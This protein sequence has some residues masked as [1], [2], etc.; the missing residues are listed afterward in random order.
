MSQPTKQ[1]FYPNP[2][3]FPS[4]A[5]YDAHRQTLDQVY[6]LHDR[7]DAME[8]KGSA[9]SGKGGS[10]GSPSSLNGLPVIG[11]PSKDQSTLIF[12]A[13]TGQLEWKAPS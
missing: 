9:P 12:N 11:S 2:S 7:L 13:K 3:D 4:H 5:Q 6:Q 8:K 1:R 10:D